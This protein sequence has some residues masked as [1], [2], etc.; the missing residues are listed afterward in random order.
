V[1]GDWVE[2]LAPHLVE[3]IRSEPHWVRATGQVAAWERV[4]FGELT[5]VPR[6]RVPWG[7]LD[8]VDARN[9]FI[10]SALVDGDCELDAPFVRHNR[11]LRDRIEALEAKRRERGLLVD[12]EARFAF[13]DARVPATVHSLPS[14]ERWRRHAESRDP[15]LLFM[16]ESDLL[17]SAPDAGLE[18][19][20]PDRLALGPS[21]SAELR[22]ELAPGTPRDG[23]HAR[24]RLGDL[25]GV[26]AERLEWMVPGLLADKVE[27]LARTLPKPVRVRLFPLREVAEGV[28]SGLAFGEGPLLEAVADRL[29]AVAGLAISAADFDLS[30]LPANLRIHLEVEDDAGR[31]LA[32]GDDLAAVRRALAPAVAARRAGLA[33]RAFGD[34][35]HRDGLKG[36]DL[37]VLPSTVEA[38]VDGV[39]VVGWP[40]LAEQGD[41]I[42]L[43]LASGPDE[44]D[45]ATRRALRRL[46]AREAA[47]AIGHHAEFAAGFDELALA[48]QASTGT[49]GDLLREALALQVAGRAFVDGRPVP[50]TPAEFQARLDSPEPGLVTVAAE[51]VRALHALHARS[52]EVLEALEG[53]VPAGWAASLADIRSQ[54]AR[55]ASPATLATADWAELASLV[56]Y[57]AA[58]AVRARRLGSGGAARDAEAMA[59]V[60]RWESELARAEAALAAEGRDP[61]DLH[62]FRTLLEEYRVSLFAQELRT[63]VPVSAERLERAW[64]ARGVR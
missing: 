4:Q 16:A 30:Q 63:A 40:M 47:G 59:A 33:A 39:R 51:A 15:R 19:R 32:S 23:V 11:D 56:R 3:R 53:P 58:L 49:G 38:V 27:A 48:W 37:D 50:R 54:R 10:Q 41:G 64:R 7:P 8:P 29:S 17:A 42:S 28:A 20:F 21:A 44:A 2:R 61:A 24:I 35:W 55:L 1:Q 5:V 13:F 34:R 18:A 25:A 12:G 57:M 22:Y 60:A 62:A 43:R 6:R 46:F 9:I 52:L 31:V 45:R 26:D 14:F 36:F